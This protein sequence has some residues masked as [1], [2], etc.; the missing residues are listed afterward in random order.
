MNR[1][2]I[3]FALVGIASPAA[4]AEDA[5]T[6]A[7]E[8]AEALTT[9]QMHVCV[10]EA[11]RQADSQL[12]EALTKARQRA[13]ADLQAPLDEAQASWAQYRDVQ[14][15]A[16][17]A[18]YEGGTIQPV[19]VLSCRLNLSRSRTEYLDGLFQIP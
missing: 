4:C 5:D 12:A 17:G 6:T 8:C 9:A 3:A 13:G 14:C 18:Q 2:V 15:A 7:D 10:N 11:N 1:M 19:V 16:E